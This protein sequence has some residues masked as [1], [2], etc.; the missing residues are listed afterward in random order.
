[1]CNLKE[2][3]EFAWI[4]DKDYCGQFTLDSVVWQGKDLSPLE[5]YRQVC[6]RIHVVVLMYDTLSQLPP[7]RRMSA[8]YIDD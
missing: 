6:E 3:T 7:I 2:N 5:A 4:F 1:M 8:W